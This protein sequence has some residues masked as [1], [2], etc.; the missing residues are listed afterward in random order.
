MLGCHVSGHP[1][2]LALDFV[3]VDRL[4]KNHNNGT[5]RLCLLIQATW[6]GSAGGLATVSINA[7]VSP[8]SLMYKIGPAPCG[9]SWI[10]SSLILTSSSSLSLSY[11]PFSASSNWTIAEPVLEALL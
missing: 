8:K 7:D 1:R 10:A 6:T 4:R 9:R 5:P 2:Q 3:A 11:F